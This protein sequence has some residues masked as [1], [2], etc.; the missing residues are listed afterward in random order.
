MRLLVEECRYDPE[1]L[2][3]VL[4]DSRLLLTNEKVKIEYVGYLRSAAC[5]D[6]VFFLPKVILEPKDGQNLIL[7]K[8]TPEQVID[9]DK[10]PLAP[11][12][13]DFLYEFAVWIYRA[14]A[15]YDETHRGND[16]VWR[17]CEWQSGGFRRR[18][19]TNTLLDV[20]LALVRFGRDNESYFTFKVK[21]Q[22]SG[23]NRINWARTIAKSPAIIHDGGPVYLEPRSRKKS[24]NFDEE[25][26]VIFYSILDYVNR[27][28][29]FRV[30]INLGYEL[31]P[32]AAFRRYL[33]GYGETR[34]RQIKYKYFSDRDL[35]LW[36]LCFAFFHKAHQANVVGAG[37]EYLIAKSFEI[38]F[39]A[40]IDELLGDQK[41]AALKELDDGKEIDHLYVDE[42][43]TR[44]DGQRSFYIADSKYYMIGHA[45][46]GKSVA[47]QFTYAK[48][49]LQLNLDL[50]LPGKNAS[51]K[52][53]R[54]RKP[55]K[56]TGSGLQRDEETEGYDVIPNFFISA[57][58]DKVN[59]DYDDHAVTWRGYKNDGDHYSIH[60]A[61]RLFDRDT[62]ILTHYDVNFLF[63]LKLYAQNDSGLRDSWREEV[64]T[65]FRE[66]IRDILS[67]RFSF[68]AIMP[69]DGV[70]APTF[71]AENFKQT[72][73]KVYQPFKPVN[74][75][76]VYLM[77]LLNPS[78]IP[79]DGLLSLDGLDVLH[80][81]VMEENAATRDLIGS[82][83]YMVDCALGE[84]P[85]EKLETLAAAHPMSPGVTGDAVSGV[86]IVAHVKG[87]LKSEVDDCGWCPCPADQCP[88]A[89]SVRILI[90]PFT[91]H[92]CMYRVEDGTVPQK[93]VAV[94]DLMRV[95]GHDF[96]KIKFPSE[97]C[98]VWRVVKI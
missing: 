33:N 44:Q 30:K 76:P 20:I 55:F 40:M 68:T 9:L 11:R 59:F 91:G 64:R 97:T 7:G 43:L 66:K 52:V 94:S 42:S 31:I 60:F 79:N 73:G 78:N 67:G 54:W 37:E 57:T 2:K 24:I 51:D 82:S 95:T 50:F 69:H 83:F 89:E 86:Q 29:G 25:L 34:L 98:H 53:E 81:R 47:K 75:K 26:L 15:R 13:R 58:M 92:A 41:L 19:V 74:G 62:L 3:G 65:A 17:L 18:Y 8:Y 36:D 16:A 85:T 87:S 93:D 84:D 12:E 21:E 5:D 1:V 10:S 27:Q 23:L 90:L 77:A 88:D 61:N 80:D 32:K 56:G 46:D 35:E 4:P 71:F 70:D 63:V 22:H 45:L 6:F 38:V 14:I 72:L 96:S 39:E 49:M 48:D 28:Y